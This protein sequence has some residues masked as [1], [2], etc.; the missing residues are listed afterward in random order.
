[1]KNLSQFVSAVILNRL[2]YSI[3]QKKEEEWF[4][5]S[6]SKEVYSAYCNYNYYYGYCHVETILF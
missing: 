4:H 3:S 5:L 1:M 6:S 2:Y